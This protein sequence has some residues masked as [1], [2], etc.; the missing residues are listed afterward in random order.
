MGKGGYRAD[1]LE[2]NDVKNRGGKRPK[3]GPEKGKTN[4]RLV[5]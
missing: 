2:G 5:G 4:S 3:R 1:S